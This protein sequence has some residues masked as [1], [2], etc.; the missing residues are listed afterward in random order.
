MAPK[1]LWARTVRGCC[2]EKKRPPHLP[3]LWPRVRPHGLERPVP[4]A[5]RR[6]S[7]TVGGA[8]QVALREP[9]AAPCLSR[10][11]ADS[12]R[13]WS[14]V[15]LCGVRPSLR[16]WRGRR[17]A[18]R[19]PV[20][21]QRLQ[22]QVPQAAGAPA[23]DQGG[24]RRLQHRQTVRG[25]CSQCVRVW[26]FSKSTLTGSVGLALSLVPRCDTVPCTASVAN[27]VRYAFTI[28][29]RPLHERSIG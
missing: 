24:D 23:V 17:G 11:G 27:C 4:P 21:R 28:R 15:P 1:G 12:R 7:G 8:G 6:G 26:E 19:A 13:G 5:R 3:C 25:C 29:H 18:P 22:A 9:G 2:C 10:H 20:L 14:A 16:P